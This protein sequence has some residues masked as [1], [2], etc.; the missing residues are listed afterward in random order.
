MSKVRKF[1]KSVIKRLHKHVLLGACR[2]VSLVEILVALSLMGGVTVMVLSAL[3]T[4]TKAVVVLDELTTAENVAQA[5]L[6]YTKSAVYQP[7]PAN[8]G[9]ISSLPGN[10]TVTVDAEEVYADGE[11][12][13]RTEMQKITVTVYH[14]DDVVFVKEGYKVDR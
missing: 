11:I 13:P 8:Y 14:Q 2:G 9:L 3:S 1:A 12:T 5:Q 10:Y 4:G 6:E 7:V